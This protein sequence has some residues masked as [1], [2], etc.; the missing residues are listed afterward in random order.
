MSLADLMKACEV[1]QRARA[2]IREVLYRAIT[3][4]EAVKVSD[5]TR[6][7][8]ARYPDDYDEATA[9]RVVDEVARDYAART[10]LK[11]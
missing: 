2:W 7:M 3:R 11:K 8:L 4:G 9:A 10:R 1:D 6:R 5:V